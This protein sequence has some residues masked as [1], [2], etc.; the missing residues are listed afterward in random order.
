MVVIIISQRQKQCRDK[1]IVHPIRGGFAG[2][3]GGSLITDW[4]IINRK[5]LVI[6]RNRRSVDKGHL[7]AIYRWAIYGVAERQ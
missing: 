3:A 1:M 4:F 5:E 2:E 6:A 7:S